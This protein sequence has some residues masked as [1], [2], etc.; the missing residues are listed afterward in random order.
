MFKPLPQIEPLINDL[1]E[2][3]LGGFLTSDDFKRFC[4]E[5]KIEKDWD[6]ILQD[7]MYQNRLIY[8]AD[9]DRDYSGAIDTLIVLSN[10]IY[11]S[12]KKK[13]FT[14]IND[15]LVKYIEWS[16]DDLKTNKI[17]E[18]LKYLN[19]PKELL[20]NIL[21]TGNNNAE[22]VPAIKQSDKWDYRQIKDI[23]KQMN[24]AAKG[25]D[26]TTVIY[27]VYTYLESFFKAFI[28]KK[29][30]QKKDTVNLNEMSGIVEDYIMNRIKIRDKKYP[31]YMIGL[32]TVITTAISNEKDSINDIDVDSKSDKQLAIS[33][34][35]HVNAMCRIVLIFFE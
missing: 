20:E 35:D 8:S 30:L 21:N 14:F 32:I 28:A 3:E 1:R 31:E 12:N 34:L 23:L 10:R 25:Q 24:S 13:F 15:L 26:Y 9:I 16:K 4:I 27:V 5:V 29:I 33:T 6:R 22:E 19:Q 17:I 11:F 2:L 18:G 7:V